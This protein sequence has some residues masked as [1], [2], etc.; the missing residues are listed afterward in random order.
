MAKDAFWFPH[1][2]GARNDPAISMLRSKYKT[3]GYGRYWILIELMREQSDYRLSHSLVNGYAMQCQCQPIKASEFIS[4]CIAFKLFES[5]GEYFW[6][7]SL[8]RRM[9]GKDKRAELG[10]EAALKRWNKN[11]D[12]EPNANPLPTHCV[13]NAKRKEKKRID[14]NDSPTGESVDISSISKRDTVINE[15]SA[16]EAVRKEIREYIKMRQRISDPMTDHA[17]DLMLGRLSS[18]ASSDAMKV[19]VLQQS[20]E[21]GWKTVYELKQEAHNPSKLRDMGE[22]DYEAQG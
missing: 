17:V 9:S 1:D 13:P 20:I 19:A 6:S 18:L 14:S 7:N 22:I 8:I 15:Y 16:N 3:E 10:R 2:A 5:D 11:A 12:S 21:R 4:D